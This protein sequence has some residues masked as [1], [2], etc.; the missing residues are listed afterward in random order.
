MQLTG[1]DLFFWAAGLAGHILLLGVLLIRHRATLFPLFTTLIAANIIRT[2]V[3]YFTLRH[4]TR[5]GYFLTY[6]TLAIVDVVL[7]LL[8]IYEV[9]WH[10]FRP[11][12]EWAPGIRRN[13]LWV[14]L[15]SVAVGGALTF[16]ATPATKTLRQA[17]V[18][19]GNFFSSA[20]MCELFVGLIVLAVTFG[21]PWKTHVARIAQG[22]GVYSIAGIVTDSATTVLGVANNSDAYRM[23]SHVR[24]ALYLV[25]LVYWIVTLW[26]DAPSPRQMPEKMRRQLAS[27]ERQSAADVQAI[28][29]GRG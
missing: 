9:A 14:T 7:Q 11:L 8:V 27:L 20:L 16:L 19:R 29:Q 12:G 22:L 24:I 5:H 28:R 6:W 25:C 21:L 26:L 23:L 18:I 17:V 15:A 3:L 13:L 10:I 1:L 2:V 4:G